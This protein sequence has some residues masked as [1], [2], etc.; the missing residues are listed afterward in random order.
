MVA[1]ISSGS[2]L[3]SALPYNHQK[4]YAG[5]AK[6]LFT[7]NIVKPKDGKFNVVIQ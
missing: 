6:V 5:N 2:S 7:N 1:K 4:M 3:Y